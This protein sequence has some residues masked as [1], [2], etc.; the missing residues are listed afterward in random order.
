MMKSAASTTG[1]W[2]LVILLVFGIIER[3]FVV[4]FNDFVI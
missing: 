4:Q 3:I 2:L 1:A